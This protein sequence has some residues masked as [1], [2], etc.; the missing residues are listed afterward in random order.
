[1]TVNYK[2]LIKK[3]EGFRR[4]PFRCTAGKLSI[5]YSRNLDDVGI[6]EEEADYLLEMD[7]DR[8]TEEL[9]KVITWAVP[10]DVYAALVDMHYNLGHERFMQFRKMIQCLK[11]LD[12]KGAAR[13]M[14]DS[15][16]AKQ[17]PN[18]AA[19]LANLVE[20]ANAD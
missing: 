17:V 2:E 1:M 16:W 4:F 18:R 15:K 7:L 9:D 3:H 6:T 20:N 14:L 5:G 11:M 13:E 10:N 19:E 12:F 8:H